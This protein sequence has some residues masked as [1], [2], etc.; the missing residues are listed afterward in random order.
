MI[1]NVI[2]FLYFLQIIEHLIPLSELLVLGFDETSV[3]EALIKFDND[4]EKTLDFL[5]S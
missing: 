4:K 5:I 1:H 3:S 2:I